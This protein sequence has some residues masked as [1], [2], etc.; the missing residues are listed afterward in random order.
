MCFSHGFK[1]PNQ[2]AFPPPT[3]QVRSENE[4]YAQ[5]RGV[6]LARFRR[7]RK[8]TLIWTFKS[9]SEAHAKIRLFLDGR[10]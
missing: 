3:T 1:R 5:R 4:K 6:L 7:R 10:F 9:M 2:R 8:S